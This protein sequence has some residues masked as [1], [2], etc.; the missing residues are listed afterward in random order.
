MQVTIQQLQAIAKTTAG[1][2]AAEKF[3]PIL[4]ELLP[5]FNLN[6]PAVI[7]AFIAQAM[8]ESAE[9]TRL[10]ESFNYSSEV[11]LFN[12]F[13][14]RFKTIH[15]AKTYFRKPEA[16]A[17]FVYANRMGNGDFMSGDGFRFRGRGLFQLTGRQNYQLVSNV[18][19]L[20]FVNYPDRVADPYYA[21]MTACWYWDN[22]GFSLHAR[23]GAF[24]TISKLINGGT[25]GLAERREY[26]FAAKEA[27]GIKK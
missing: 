1:K 19:A 3:A 13:P 12:T 5:K 25:N 22:R 10:T 15:I 27:L 6:E 9:F 8:H 4:N 21:V 24:N 23:N 18:L 26:W 7:A 17:N 11:R 16:I 20:D 14:T 2:K